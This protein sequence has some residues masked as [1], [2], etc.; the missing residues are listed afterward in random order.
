MT[1]AFRCPKCNGL[2]AFHDKHAGKQAK[3]VRCWQVFII[4]SK[5]GEKAKKIKIK[6]IEGKPLGGFYRAVLVDN[7]K[8]FTG[9]AN[10]LGLAF[11]LLMTICKFF[12]GGVLLKLV[13][14][15]ALMWYYMEIICV[16]GFGVDVLPEFYAESGFAFVWNII[17]SL[18]V[19]VVTL[20]LVELPFAIAIA[21]LQKAGIEWTPLRVVLLLAG[22]FFFPVGILNVAVRQDILALLR[23]DYIIRPVIKAF[24]PYMLVAGIVILTAA[25]EFKTQSYAGLKDKSWIIIVLNLAAN[26]ISAGLMIIAVRS[27]GLFFRH[28]GCYCIEDTTVYGN[29]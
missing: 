29:V 18:Y 27:V 8:I 14:W 3:C 20:I 4:P 5:D 12:V 10:I 23:A 2:C 21:L 24:R 13:I 11:I 26:I 7:W 6:K 28:Y 1:I 9:R 16:A 25:L 22:L 17:K 19:F 15:G